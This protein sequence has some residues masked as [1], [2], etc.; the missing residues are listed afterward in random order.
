MGDGKDRPDL[1]TVTEVK[2]ERQSALVDVVVAGA[3]QPSYRRK[4]LVAGL[5]AEN[6]AKT[7]RRK[8]E[9][10]KVA[11]LEDIQHYPFAMEASGHLSASALKVC[12]RLGEMAV[13][14]Y[15][16]GELSMKPRAF[17]RKLFLDLSLE[18]QRGNARMLRGGLLNNEMFR[19]DMG[20]RKR[21]RGGGKGDGGNVS[22]QLASQLLSQLHD[23]L[24]SLP[25]HHDGYPSGEVGVIE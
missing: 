19:I 20:A 8:Y 1:L 25:A 7:K 15:G 16:V 3:D 6:A 9:H 21:R 4:R 10:A 12:Q 11:G 22:D 13:E 2:G 14:Q 24:D 23:H 17:K 5:A 18:L